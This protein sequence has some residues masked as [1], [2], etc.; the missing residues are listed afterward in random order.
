M[1]VDQQDVDA[2]FYVTVLEGIVKEYDI[3]GV[4]FGQP[5]YASSSVFVDGNCDARELLP[6]LVGLITNLPHGRVLVGQ[7]VTVA[8]ALVATAQY[9]HFKLVFQ[10]LGEVFHMG[11]L[12]CASNGNVANRDDGY[13]IVLALQDAHI[14]EEIPEAYP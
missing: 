7:H 14:E 8:L 3:N 1:V 2:W 9:S 6:H 12:A 4:V 11:C 5:G 10:Q 13:F